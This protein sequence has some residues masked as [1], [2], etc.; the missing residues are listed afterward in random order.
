MHLLRNRDLG[1]L[2]TLLDAFHFFQDLAC[3]L[4][5][6]DKKDANMRVCLLHSANPRMV[7]AVAATLNFLFNVAHGKTALHDSDKQA[8]VG[9]PFC[10]GKSQQHGKEKKLDQIHCFKQLSTVKMKSD[11]ATRK[12][13][14][15]RRRSSPVESD[16]Q[17]DANA[18]GRC[19]R[20]QRVRPISL[21][22][23]G[24]MGTQQRMMRTDST[25]PKFTVISSGPST[26]SDEK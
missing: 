24:W 6:A 13:K 18:P 8:R 5:T 23:T 2:L 22:S 14:L 1:V 10:S 11:D 9:V 4:R 26:V 7:R 16:D 20:A 21:H 12:Q 3:I 25:A 15:V 19:N 17:D